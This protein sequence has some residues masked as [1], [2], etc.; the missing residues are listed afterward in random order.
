MPE[1]VFEIYADDYDRWFDE[2][3]NE[4]QSE[5][6][7]IKSIT[8]YIAP[9]LNQTLPVIEVGCGPGRFAASLGIEIGIEPSLSLCRIARRRGIDI[10][11]GRAEALPVKSNLC[12]AAFLITVICFLDSPL[13]ALK[14]LCR[15]LVP[16][17]HLTIAFILRGGDIHRKYL[18][19]GGKGRFLKT[20]T[21]YSEEEIRSFLKKS[22]FLINETESYAGFFV[23]LA[24]KV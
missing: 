2:H 15:I 21:F 9:Q 17:C 23:I 7:C 1:D 20:A 14:E 6:S 3:N 13:T 5:L 16:G 12:R 22:G 10:V 18:D 24:Q 4:F 8:G 19:E 11:R